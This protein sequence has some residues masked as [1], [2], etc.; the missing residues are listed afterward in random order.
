MEEPTLTR[1]L[2]WLLALTAFVLALPV[3]ADVKLPAIIGSN[4]VLQAGMPA[5]IYGWADAGEKVTVKFRDQELT[6]TTGAD[7]KWSVKLAALTAGGPDEMSIAG[8]NT[9]TLTNVLVGEV[10]VCSGQSNMGFTVQGANNAPEEIAAANYPQIRLFTVARRPSDKP[11]A[12]TTGSWVECSPQTVPGFTAVGYFFGRTLYQD[13]NV[14]VGLINS[15]WGGTM[16]EAWTSHEALAAVPAFQPV[17]QRWAD[18]EANYPQQKATYDAKL[19]DWKKRADEAKAQGQPFTERAPGQ[20]LFDMKQHMPSGLYDGMIQ[21]LIPFALRGAIWY[22]GESNAGRAYAYRE[23][24]PMLIRDWRSNWGEGPFPFYMVQLANYMARKDQPSDSA[25]AELREAQTMTAQT[26]ENCG[27]AVIID[28]GEEKDIHPKNKQDVGKRLALIALARDYG[29]A[30]EFS[31]PMYDSMAV[32]G[33]KIRLKLTH[34][35]GLV[36]QGGEPLK[37]F[38]IAGEDKQFVWADATIDGETVLVSSAQ[39]ASPVAVRYDWADNPD[40]NL[41]NAAGLPACPFRTDDWPGL[42]VGKY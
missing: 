41:Y 13:L 15:S 19:A 34:A 7:G 35:E 25:W 30:V 20:P 23:L 33:N 4:M 24:M 8:N 2:T 16:A 14:P 12:D 18:A 11:E 22:Q 37:G 17:F 28:I 6:A 38:A 36:A 39:V 27:Q 9:L 5:P 3:V 21:P 26:V 32:E 10:W 42:T 1:R 31:G 29:K 40:G